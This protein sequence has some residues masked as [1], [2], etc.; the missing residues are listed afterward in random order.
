[1]RRPYEFEVC[2]GEAC[3]ACLDMHGCNG[4]AMQ[5]PL[6][7]AAFPP[8]LPDGGVR[9]PPQIALSVLREPIDMPRQQ[10]A[11]LVHVVVRE[12]GVGPY[13]LPGFFECGSHEIG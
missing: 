3:L 12:L 2:R 9:Q 8:Q 5:S 1:M 10:S 11:H 4:R 7:C 13:E 6:R